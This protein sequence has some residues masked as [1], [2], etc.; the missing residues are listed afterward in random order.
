MII[1]LVVT[2]GEAHIFKLNGHFL[3]LR[4]FTRLSDIES[5]LS[6]DSFVRVVRR[7]RHS[8]FQVDSGLMHEQHADRLPRQLI[9][10]S[11][12]EFH[13]FVLVGCYYQVEII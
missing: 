5:L 6:Q 7:V 13:V 10:L 3:D 4:V 1:P 2:V 9:K 12:R 11:F 8:R